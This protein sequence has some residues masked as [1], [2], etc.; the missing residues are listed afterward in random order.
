VSNSLAALEILDERRLFLDKVV[1]D[2][3][4][5][6]GAG[7]ASYETVFY[8]AW[9]RAPVG[10]E[11]LIEGYLELASEQDIETLLTHSDVLKRKLGQM[12]QRVAT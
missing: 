3:T 8:N 5:A 12:A 2:L 9:L 11:I 6:V 7:N 10:R 4:I 1:K